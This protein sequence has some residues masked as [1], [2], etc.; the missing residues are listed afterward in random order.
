MVTIYYIYSKIQFSIYP[1]CKSTLMGRW[2]VGRCGA[3][4]CASQPF[5]YKKRIDVASKRTNEQLNSFR[6]CVRLTFYYYIY[7]YIY[8]NKSLCTFSHTK[9][10]NCSFVRSKHITADIEYSKLE[11]QTMSRRLEVEF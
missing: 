11:F 2:D 6:F 4:L 5:P 9:L 1:C 8:N 3:I 7:N 10:F